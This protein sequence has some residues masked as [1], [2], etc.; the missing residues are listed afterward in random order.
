[1]HMSTG[2]MAS[3]PYARENRVSPAGVRFA[4]WYAQS[5]PGSVSTHLPFALPKLLHKP[6]R[7]DYLGMVVAL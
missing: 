5:T 6:S 3:V 1:M 4:I 2:I 7:I